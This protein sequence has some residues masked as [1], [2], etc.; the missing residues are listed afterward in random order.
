MSQQEVLKI[1]QLPGMTIHTIHNLIHSTIIKHN[2]V[3]H[4]THIIRKWLL[5]YHRSPTSEP[6]LPY[7]MRAHI[8]STDEC[9]MI[10][11]SLIKVNLDHTKARKPLVRR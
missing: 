6:N 1:P 7:L 3:T 4:A 8:D 10:I 9:K 2:N 5:V 11:S